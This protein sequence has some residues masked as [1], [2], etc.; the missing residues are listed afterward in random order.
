[1]N[2]EERNRGFTLM[3]MVVVLAVIAVLAAILTPVLTSFVDRARLNS[4][5]NDVKNIAAAIAHYNTDLKFYPIYK[6]AGTMPSPATS[7][8]WDW[9]GTTGSDA[10]FTGVGWAALTDTSGSLSLNLN[11][12]FYGAATAGPPGVQSYRGPY[13][14]L[15]PDPWGGRYYVT[16]KNLK[17]GNS[18]Y[19]AYV[20]SAGPNGAIETDFAQDRTGT[21]DFTVGGD[22]IVTRIR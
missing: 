21:L 4:A 9:Q 15:G 2:K 11:T 10:A 22:D 20:I 7:A 1:V 14:E 12:N 19:A 13:F 17:P 6:T 3:E 5:Q 18:N 8:A 16:S